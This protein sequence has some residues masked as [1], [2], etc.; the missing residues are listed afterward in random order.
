MPRA[1]TCVPTRRSSSYS[2]VQENNF[3]IDRF[4]HARRDVSR[5]YPTLGNVMDRTATADPNEGF[6]N[7]GFR[8]FI[9]ASRRTLGARGQIR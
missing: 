5:P 6:T 1:Q 9:Q 4:S 8:D 2:P 3:N 7:L